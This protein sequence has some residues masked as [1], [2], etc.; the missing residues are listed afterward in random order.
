[1]PRARADPFIGLLDRGEVVER[2]DVD[3]GNAELFEP[4]APEIALVG[5]VAAVR[6]V[7]VVGPEDQGLAIL[8]AVLQQVKRS[9]QPRRQ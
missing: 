3:H 5:A 1:M 6:G 4:L 2:I 9:G 7:G 8:K